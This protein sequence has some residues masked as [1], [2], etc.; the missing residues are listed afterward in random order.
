MVTYDR[1]RAQTV[2][3]KL[4]VRSYKK[5][6][7]LRRGERLRMILRV[8]KM[9]WKEVKRVRKCERARDEMV[10]DVNG[11]ILRDGVEVR[12]RLPEY[13]SRGMGYEKC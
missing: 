8:K 6:G 5:N 9:F 10:N 4:A 12:R 1:Y 11:Q 7:D 13:P 2:V 3:V